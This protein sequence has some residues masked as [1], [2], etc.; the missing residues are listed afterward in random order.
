M[1]LGKSREMEGNVEIGTRITQKPRKSKTYG[2]NRI[3]EQDQ[4]NQILSKYNNQ[5][6]CFQDHKLK[7]ARVRGHELVD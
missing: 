2:D 3:C 1:V 5:E 4:C 6:F 7:Y